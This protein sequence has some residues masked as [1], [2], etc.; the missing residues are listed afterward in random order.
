[1]PGGERATVPSCPETVLA[2]FATGRRRRVQAP[3]PRRGAALYVLL[4]AGA[5][6]FQCPGGG[7]IQLLKTAE[8]LR[9]QGI[10][11]KLFNPWRDKL[12]DAD[13]LHLF[14]TLREH[15]PLVAAARHAGTPTVLSTIAWYDLRAC[16]HLSQNRLGGAWRSGRFLLRAAIPWAASWRRRLYREVDLLLP[17][18][19]AEAAQLRRYFC[20]PAAKILVVPNGADLPATSDRPS[21]VGNQAGEGELL[22]PFAPRTFGPSSARRLGRSTC[23]LAGGP[24]LFAAMFGVRDYVLCPGRIEPRKNQLALVRALADL[25]RPVVILGDALPE[26]GAYAAACRRAAG[27]HVQFIPAV[28]RDSPLLASAYACAACVV[29]PGWFETPGL[30]ALEASLAG[31]PLVVTRVGAAREYFGR[32]ARYIRPN[33]PADIAAAVRDALTNRCGDWQKT[34]RLAARVARRYTWRHVAE[35]CREA[36]ER[37]VR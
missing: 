21:A 32:W 10:R 24:D 5:S 16:W 28:P 13:C 35:A 30:A 12:R 15:V 7:E 31:V 3:V 23:E 17:N 8:Y 9:R 36:Y 29:L 34:Q 11:A 25:D 33:R 26:H 27:A 18:S 22:D 20:V 6:A 14:G 19:R 2:S 1:M 37:V 4:Y